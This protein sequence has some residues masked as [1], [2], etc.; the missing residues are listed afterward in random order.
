MSSLTLYEIGE[1]YQNVISLAEMGELDDE[2][3]SITLGQI[4][5]ELETKA[6]SYKVVIDRLSADAEMFKA[7]E[8][9]LQD[10]RK[11]LERNIGQMKKNLEEA[12]RLQ[13]K[14]KIKTNLFSF[15]IQKNPPSVVIFDESA[16]GEAYKTYSVS[17]DKKAIKEALKAGEEVPGA[18][19]EQSESL[20]IR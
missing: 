5:D 18:K 16:I 15:S 1:V 6:D 9:R 3:L 4:E 11:R 17:F 10:K 19:L 20:R 2:T 14:S 13:G 12:M 8:K 7:E